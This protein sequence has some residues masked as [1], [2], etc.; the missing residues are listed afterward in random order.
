MTVL[1]PFN[2]LKKKGYDHRIR[3]SVH[4]SMQSVREDI[5]RHW[6]SVP[7]GLAY[8][9]LRANEQILSSQVRFW[10]VIF[11]DDDIP[12]GIA[13]FQLFRLDARSF[14]G[15]AQQQGIF[16]RLEGKL[17]ELLHRS[18]GLSKI[19]VLLCGDL[20]TTAP[21][22]FWFLP[23]ISMDRRWIY[24]MTAFRRVRQWVS[25]WVSPEL[26]V[27]KDFSEGMLPSVDHLDDSGF[28]RISTDPNMVL[29]IAPH[30][31]SLGDY[32][33]ALNSHYRRQAATVI[34]TSSGVRCEFLSREAA[35]HHS[36]RLDALHEQVYEKAVIR[37]SAVPTGYFKLMASQMTDLFGLRGYF[38]NGILVGFVSYFW[39]ADSM[40]C[41]YLGMDYSVK[42]QVPLYQLMLYD[43]LDV[44]IQKGV[45]RIEYGRTA[46]EI[47]ASLGAH[48]VPTFAM[49]KHRNVI[50]DQL[51]DL[52]VALMHAVEFKERHV[53][54]TKGGDT[55]SIAEIHPE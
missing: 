51:I 37:Y 4:E 29:D 40:Q 15:A 45:K 26:M 25:D 19:W 48:P 49:V 17:K 31:R 12:V 5:W 52:F 43:V 7:F 39:D 27:I 36:A 55:P 38:Y 6:T 3:Y 10:V 1:H 28:H 44:A 21:H 13:Q 18:V 22:A 50:K 32:M 20:Y 11:W 46:S 30:W 33:E 47:K 2:W 24:L 54:K 34:A 42:N 53:Y 16:D 41:Q 8:R 9:Q 23:E 35:I 14:A